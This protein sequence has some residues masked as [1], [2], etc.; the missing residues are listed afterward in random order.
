MLRELTLIVAIVLSAIALCS[1]AQAQEDEAARPWTRA[2]QLERGASRLDV[3]VR[4]YEPADGQ[5]PT[6]ALVGAVHI[7]DSTFYTAAQALLDGHDLVLFEGVGT[8]DAGNIEPGSDADHIL[9]TESRMAFL[10]AMTMRYAEHNGEHPTSLGELIAPGQ[11]LFDATLTRKIHALSSDAWGRPIRIETEGDQAGELVSYGADGQPLGDGPD[12]DIRLPMEDSNEQNPALADLYTVL[13]HAIGLS[14]Q[15]ERMLSDQPGWVNSD[16]HWDQLRERIGDD[17]AVFNFLNQDQGAFGDDPQ[18]EMLIRM[19][20]QTVST[21]P[22]IR[23]MIKQMMVTQLGSSGTVDNIGAIAGEDFEQV[24]IRD[25]NQ[26]VI[27]DLERAIADQPDTDSIALFYGA[28][29]MPDMEDRLQ[30]QLDYRY[31]SELWLPAITVDPAREGL[32]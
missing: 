12:A 7:A 28:G 6:V 13:A 29:H 17:N 32:R 30:D 15:S 4:F 8:A 1:P 20:T 14:T 5:G 10:Q 9:R 16:M 24:I 31:T 27:D 19:A 22:Q 18:T 11:V 23:L 25:R 21:S 26:V 2:V 3:A